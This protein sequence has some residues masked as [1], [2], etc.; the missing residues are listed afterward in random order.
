MGKTFLMKRIGYHRES[1]GIDIPYVAPASKV[2]RIIGIECSAFTQE[3]IE[4]KIDTLLFF[5]NYAVIVYL[6]RLFNGWTVDGIV[7]S[8]Q[9]PKGSN[10]VKKRVH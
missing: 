5:W 9:S 3:L 6:C 10:L 8:S 4:I 2:G 1:D 7:F